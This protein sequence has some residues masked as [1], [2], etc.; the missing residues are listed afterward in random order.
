M[1]GLADPDAGGNADGTAAEEEVVPGLAQALSAAAE[2]TGAALKGLELSVGGVRSVRLPHAEAFAAIPDRALIL[3]L[4]SGRGEGLAGAVA[5]APQLVDALVEVQTLGR[6]EAVAR[7]ARIPT[8]IDATLARPFVSTLLASTSERVPSAPIPAPDAGAFHIDAGPVARAIE[9]PVIVHA[10]LTV[11]FVDGARE[12]TLDILLPDR[13]KS[14]LPAP[15]SDGGK[16][17][18]KGRDTKTPAKRSDPQEVLLSARVRLE[19]VLPT[20]TIPLSQM[21]DLKV[22]DTIALTPDAVSGLT[23]RGGRL[24]GSTPSPRACALHGVPGKLGQS[25]GRRAIKLL[26]PSGTKAG[27]ADPVSPKTSDP[28]S[29]GPAMTR[30]TPPVPAPRMGSPSPIAPAEPGLPDLPDL[31]DLSDLAS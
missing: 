19:A 5:L 20:V 30:T 12:A 29:S 2:R 23:L 21:L 15:K 31:P 13:P 26:D 25:A 22:G 7:P 1:A 9:A 28:A 3:P 17:A 16:A 6:V 27:S 10:R 14:A 4:P 18:G 8:R 24:G 11:S